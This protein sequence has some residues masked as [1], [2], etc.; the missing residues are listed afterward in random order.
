MSSLDWELIAQDK[1]HAAAVIAQSLNTG[2][3]ALFLGAGLSM[4]L[5][6]PSWTGLL[7]RTF[8]LLPRY[9]RVDVSGLDATGL[10]HQFEEVREFVGSK[11][12]FNDVV[13]RSLYGDWRPHLGNWANDLLISLGTLLVPGRRGH[14]DTVLTLNFDNILELYLR[15]YGFLAQ[16]SSVFPVIRKNA[17]VM[18]YHSHGF[19]PFGTEC[20]ENETLVLDALSYDREMGQQNSSRRR[21]ME[22]VIHQK[23]VLGVGSSGSDPYSNAILAA[24]PNTNPLREVV[25]YWLM[26]AK[27]EDPQVRRFY[28]RRIFP[29]L[30]GDHSEIPSFLLTVSEK[31]AARFNF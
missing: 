5:G 23:I 27:K 13:R 26:V 29:V 22:S 15:A 17:D 18:V 1:E 20:V 4:S 21:M 10:G 24:T 11:A 7:E 6:L 25:G 14:I 16:S 28:R 2:E 31:A 3:L 12:A 30:F 8:D 9:P 19:L